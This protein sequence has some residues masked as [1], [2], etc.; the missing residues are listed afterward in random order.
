[1]TA[2]ANSEITVRKKFRKTTKDDPQ[3]QKLMRTVMQVEWPVH[4][5]TSNPD[6]LIPWSKPSPLIMSAGQVCLWRCATSERGDRRHALPMPIHTTRP[7]ATS[8]KSKPH[9]ASL[10]LVGRVRH[11]REVIGRTDLD[12][13]GSGFE[14]REAYT[15]LGGRGRASITGTGRNSATLTCSHGTRQGS[16]NRSTSAGSAAPRSPGC[17]EPT[18]GLTLA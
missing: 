18:L 9:L 5:L 1:M 13:V 2:R 6:L 3:Q 14:P 11:R 10:L 17:C 16:P 7:A 12:S 15:E 4:A 8:N